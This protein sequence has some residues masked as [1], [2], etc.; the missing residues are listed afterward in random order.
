M[1]KLS[2][3]D[4]E[5]ARFHSRSLTD[6]SLDARCVK[7]PTYRGLRKPRVKCRPCELLYEAERHLKAVAAR[8]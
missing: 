3:F 6:Y 1:P 5:L 4:V 8:G 7:H 2:L